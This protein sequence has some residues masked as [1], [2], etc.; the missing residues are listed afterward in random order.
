MQLKSVLSSE[1]PRRS[2]AQNRLTPWFQPKASQSLSVLP[3]VL[4]LASCMHLIVNYDPVTYKSLTDLKA[5]TMLFF[6]E[7]APNKPYAANTTQFED[8][9]VKIE[10]IYEYEK[11][12]K[13]NNE[14]IAQVTEIRSMI[15]DMMT[16][17]KQQDHLSEFYVK[18]KKA[19][20]EKAFDIAIA[21]ENSKT[22]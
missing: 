11:G 6:A 10:R 13:L 15:N 21:T 16:L 7:M 5:E 8:F 20:I 18:E 19:Q 22:K 1:S 4:F 12:K 9:K 17:Y 14:T 3:L 2:P